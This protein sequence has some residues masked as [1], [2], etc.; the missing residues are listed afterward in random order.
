MTLPLEGPKGARRRVRTAPKGLRA[1]PR[2]S[3]TIRGRGL[4]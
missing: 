2:S 4:T 1:Y 3:R